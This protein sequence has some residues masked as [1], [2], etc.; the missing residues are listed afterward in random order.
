L[1]N[2][3]YKSE[4]KSIIHHSSKGF[5]SIRKEKWKLIE[6]LGS[7]GFSKPVFIEPNQGETI[8]SLFNMDED[9]SETNNLSN[10][11]PEIVKGLIT[12]MNSIK[13]KSKNLN[14][15]Y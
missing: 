8:Y 7:G 10:K 1:I 9:I 15:Y 6:N 12:E 5:F 11:Y 4:P 3:N 14:S 2:D 13:K